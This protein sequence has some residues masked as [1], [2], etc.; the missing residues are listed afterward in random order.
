[1]TIFPLVAYI[2][3]SIFEAVGD[4]LGKKWAIGDGASFLL[5]TM[6][7][8]LMSGLLFAVSL[9]FYELSTASMMLAAI[10]MLVAIGAGV[11]LFNESITTTKIIA[12]VLLLIAF[13]LQI[14]ES[15]KG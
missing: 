12:G 13:G 1:M 11:W 7:L 8:Y 4:I 2:L 6:G 3:M 14:M 10:N 9:K 5:L 15:M